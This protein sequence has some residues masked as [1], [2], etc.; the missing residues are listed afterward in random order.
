VHMIQHKL[1]WPFMMMD[2]GCT[3]MAKTIKRIMV[4][5]CISETIKGSSQPC[6][7]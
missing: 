5:G 2:D 3:V 1:Q 6:L 7:A 4:A